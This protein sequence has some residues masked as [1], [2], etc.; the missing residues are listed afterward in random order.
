MRITGARDPHGRQRADQAPE[1]IRWQT[2]RNK[3]ALAVL[4]WRG[5]HEYRALA[6]KHVVDKSVDRA[7]Y[8]RRECRVIE[9]WPMHCRDERRKVGARRL[10]K[11][12]DRIDL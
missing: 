7:T 10:H 8:A 5:E 9:A 11:K 6:S 4:R 3:R 2:A 1:Q 12:R